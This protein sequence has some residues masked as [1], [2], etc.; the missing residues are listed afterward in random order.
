MIQISGKGRQ[1]NLRL[2]RYRCLRN[3][4]ALEAGFL[5]IHGSIHPCTKSVG[6]PTLHYMWDSTCGTRPGI[7]EY[8]TSDIYGRAR[9]DEEPC[10]IRG[11]DWEVVKARNL[12][13]SLSW[14]LCQAK[15]VRVSPHT[16]AYVSI[17]QHTSAYVSIVKDVCTSVT[18]ES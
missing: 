7:R 11:V 2:T 4:Y 15:G 16:S 9:T 6:M 18:A 14:H 1:G 3:T 10:T 17:R 5:H 13:A 12:L 8:T